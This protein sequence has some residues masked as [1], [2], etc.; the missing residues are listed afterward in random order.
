MNETT[1]L[2]K[3]LDR[4]FRKLFPDPILTPKQMEEGEMTSERG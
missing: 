4:D 2:M 3:Q 1:D